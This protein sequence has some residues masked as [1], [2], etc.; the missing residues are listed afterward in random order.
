M[1]SQPLLLFTL[2]AFLGG[3]SI[4]G[5]V[6][7]KTCKALPLADSLGVN[8]IYRLDLRQP[9]RTVRHQMVSREIFFAY[10]IGDEFNDRLSLAQLQQRH[11]AQKKIAEEK[12]RQLASEEAKSKAKSAGA[13]DRVAALFLRRQDM[14]PET[15]GF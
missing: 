12:A 13:D 9:D 6:V 14:L 4:H 2:S 11:Q 7:D 15:E 1:I 10:E 8:A 3:G 5:V